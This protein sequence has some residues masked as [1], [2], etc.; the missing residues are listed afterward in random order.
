VPEKAGVPPTPKVSSET[1]NLVVCV[2]D[3]PEVL[4]LLKNHLEAE[5]FE[6]VGISDSRSAVASL[7]QHK[8]VLVT[9]DI[10][11]PNK[12][13]WQI[14][15]ELKADPELK[16]IPVV[17]HSVVDNKALA[18]SLGAESYIVKPVEADKIISVVRNYTGT[19][20][21]EILV[22]DDNEDFT[23][24]LRNLLEKSKFRISTARNGVE[25]IE[26]LRTTSH[27][28]SSWIFLCPRW[29]GLKWRKNEPGRKTE[30]STDSSAHREGSDRAGKVQ[31]QLEDKRHRARKDGLTREI[32]LREVNK[33]I[34]RKK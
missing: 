34:R 3:D 6:F 28:W 4:L 15:Q 29:T 27:R 23:N 30:G 13:G 7:K 19:S 26:F 11:M 10:M 32:I 21:G 18:V 31:P 1:N 8:P 25:A 16:D 12:D 14:L 9:L 5:G 20:G 33:F 24:F 17:I 22:V 2:D